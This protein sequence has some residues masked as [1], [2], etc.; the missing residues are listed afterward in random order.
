MCREK[1]LLPINLGQKTQLN[2]F[3]RLLFAFLFCINM[4]TR[5]RGKKKK[6]NEE[7]QFIGEEDDD[8]EVVKDIF[9]Y[10]K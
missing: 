10:K 5:G 9:F 8:E 2:R 6:P 1:Y 4:S 3:S 7:E